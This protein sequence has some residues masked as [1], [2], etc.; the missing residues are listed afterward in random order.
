MK[1]SVIAVVMLLALLFAGITTLV[2]NI[3]KPVEADNG[4]KIIYINADGTITPPEANITT[5]DYVTYTFNGT[6]LYPIV[7]NRSNI[8]ID[9]NG[10]A[11]QGK[12]DYGSF[13]ISLYNLINVTIANVTVKDFCYG[14]KLNE[15][16]SIKI[17]ESAFNNT[18]YN[19]WGYDTYKTI[20]SGNYITGGSLGIDFLFSFS[21]TIFGNNITGNTYA[22]IELTG[23]HNTTISENNISKNKRSAPYPWGNSI[24]MYNSA[25]SQIYDNNITEGHNGI[26]LDQYNN[27]AI[28][29]NNIAT[30]GWMGIA[31]GKCINVSM[32][33]NLL[34]DTLYGLDVWGEELGYYLHSID[35]SNLI[36][37]K[38]V[39]YLINQRHTIIDASTYPQVGFLALINSTDVTVEGL[40]ITK[41]AEGI[42]V[43]YAN[44]TGIQNNN[45]TS[46][47]YGVGL[48][49]SSNSTITRNVIQRNT[50]GIY[51]TKSTNTAIGGNTLEDNDEEGIDIYYST[52]CTV[53]NN[54]ISGNNYGIR[55]SYS[56]TVISENNISALDTCISI[57]SSENIIY[58]N[59]ITKGYY[60]ISLGVSSNNIIRQN[61]ITNNEYGIDIYNSNNNTICENNIANNTD[62]IYLSESEN[63]KIYHNNFVNN[64]N[65]I[66]T[67]AS[68]CTWDNGYPS[69]GNYWSDHLGV[70]ADYDGI[71]DTQYEIDADNVDRYPLMG[72]IN[73]FNVGEW[74]DAEQKIEIISNS[75]VSYFQLDIDKKTLSFNLTGESA[76]GFCRITIPNIIVQELWQN[77]YTVLLNGEPLDFIN[78]TYATD[79]Y[80]YINYTHSEHQIIIVPEFP[81][82]AMPLILVAT[83]TLIVALRKKI[84][85]K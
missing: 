39:Y 75:T 28:Y 14:I 80:I 83:A 7:V 69:G 85:V 24:L 38:P 65:R 82:S 51:I 45:L 36:D 79:T 5:T 64:T 30:H 31:L 18:W 77:N 53:H 47:Y 55:I 8:I 22:G 68:P 66:S 48:A 6:N 19:I 29:R 12:K 20:I 73:V 70:D 13:G 81:S 35:T 72:P 42:L 16:T 10:F 21:D 46:N 62:S 9:G 57:D 25:N 3:I 63:N 11:V 74:D 15:T 27:T 58:A 43:A 76:E 59:N 49:N 26:N 78:W 40:N 1:N 52:N 41:S 23:A 61:N 44:N 4:G 50:Y 67:Y 33:N 37:G 17:L 34:N 71:S 84:R 32:H 56:S 54:E 2:S 60:G